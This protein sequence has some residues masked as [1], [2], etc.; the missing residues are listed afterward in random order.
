MG[1]TKSS[2]VATKNTRKIKKKTK[3]KVPAGYD[4]ALEYDLHNKELKQWEYH[5][6][7]RVNYVVPSS[8]EP[9]FKAQVCSTNGLGCTECRCRCVHQEIL[10]EVKGRFRTREEASKYIHIRQ[11][12]KENQEIIFLFQDANK[13]MPF[14]R[15]R[16]DGTKQTHGEWAEKNGFRFKCLRK[17]LPKKW[18]TQM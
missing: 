2:A 16:K 9:D 11:A 14:V 4:S 13:P 1:I 15:K 5:P 12:L 17:G 7:E 6:T 10:L 18:L 3:R 8:Y